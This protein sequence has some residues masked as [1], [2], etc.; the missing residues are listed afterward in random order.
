MQTALFRKKILFYTDTP[1]HGG[2]ERHML[3]LARNLNKEKYQVALICSKYKQLDLWCKEWASNGFSVHRIKVVH[4][5]DPR[6][7][8]QMKQILNREKPD[9]LHIHLWNPGACRYAFGA[10]NTKTTKILSTEHD[11]FPL[12]GLKNSFKKNCLKKT[13]FT[14]AVSDA[15]REMLLKLYPQVKNKITTVHNGI[16]LEEFRQPLIHFANQHRLMIRQ[17][18]FNAGPQDFV[19][20]SVAALHERKGLKYLLEAFAKV[21]EKKEN[22]KLAIV[23]EGPER[24]NLEKLIKNLRIDNKVVLTGVQNEIAKL[25]KSADLFVLPSIKEA[26]G[27]AV[28]EAMDAGIPIIGSNTG[29]IPE[30]IENGK[31]GNLVEPRDAQGLADKILEL[32]ENPPLCQKL[33]YVASHEVKKFDVMEMLKKTEKIYDYLLNS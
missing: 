10:V 31:T 32:M 6:T 20:I 5:H 9:L 4:K 3:L 7:L 28:V 22:A 14:I 1:I 33:T 8:G 12:T 23:G 26:F 16:D 18:L 27:L 2:A 15:N 17:K 29:G 13:D 19:I 11:P 24:K 25:L 21:A 30:I